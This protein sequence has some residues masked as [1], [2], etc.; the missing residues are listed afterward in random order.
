MIKVADIQINGILHFGAATNFINVFN[1]VK[2]NVYFIYDE[3]KEYYKFENIIKLFK[4]NAENPV[5]SLFTDD[6]TKKE[7][8]FE[9]LKN[10]ETIYVG[11]NRPQDIIKL[12]QTTIKI[13]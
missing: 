4:Q 8:I 11:M 10:T 7:Q 3:D 5:V 9:I 6:E 12:N 2:D 13:L 1:D